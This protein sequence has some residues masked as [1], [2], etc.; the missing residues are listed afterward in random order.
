MHKTS[1][2]KLK[3][4]TIASKRKDL[5]THNNMTHQ[6]IHKTY[7]RHLQLLQLKNGRE[8]ARNTHI[9]ESG[10]RRASRRYGLHCTNWY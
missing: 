8:I 1:N 3:G 4:M 2:M 5:H 9:G 7:T 6:R 10:R